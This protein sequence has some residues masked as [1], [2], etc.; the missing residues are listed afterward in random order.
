[1]KSFI[2][3]LILLI[4]MFQLAS[5][6]Y[7]D[8]TPK[9]SKLYDTG[10]IKSKCDLDAEELHNIFTDDVS[11]QIECLETNFNNFIKY[12]KRERSDAV[13]EAELQGFVRKFFKL[14]SDS[15]IKGLRF[16]FELNM[17]LLNDHRSSISTDNI[18]PLFLIMQKIN[19]HAVNIY[20]LMNK[21]N[22]SNYLTYRD[23]IINEFSNLM[24]VILQIVDNNNNNNEMSAKLNI[25]NFIAN[26]KEKFPSYNI[27]LKTAESLL[28]LKKLFLGG[29]KTYINS[30]EVI[31]LLSK[32]SKG[33]QIGL[34]LFFLNAKSFTEE[35]ELYLHYGK[36]IQDLRGLFFP[37]ND[38]TVLFQTEDLAE[39]LRKLFN[40]SIDLEKVHAVF[41]SFQKNLLGKESDSLK[42]KDL[43]VALHYLEIATTSIPYKN[44]LLKK[45]EDIDKKEYFYKKTIINEVKSDMIEFS[46]ELK[47]LITRNIEF[48]K[49]Q[50]ILEFAID[51]NQQYP[52][53]DKLT[54]DV[55]GSLFSVKTLLLGGAKESF[56]KQNIVDLLI[57]A[58]DLAENILNLFYINKRDL[59]TD[60]LKYQFFLEISNKLKNVFH[61]TDKILGEDELVI[62]RHELLHIADYMSK[63]SQEFNIHKFMKSIDAIKTKVIGGNETNYMLSDIH[64]IM[65]LIIKGFEN[66]LYFNE[67]YKANKR[68]FKRTSKINYIPRV[69]LPIYSKIQSDQL[70]KLHHS[71]VHQAK[72]YRYFRRDNGVAYY[73]FIIKRTRQGFVESSMINFI[74][75]ILQKAYGS[76]DGDN[77]IN[78]SR[79]SLKA[80][81][82]DFKPILLEFDMWTVS[83]DDFVRN[84]LL[85]SD[86][87]QNTSNST[88]FLEIDET[89]EFGILVLQAMKLSQEVFTT[90]KH[91][92][93]SGT[94]TAEGVDCSYED[95]DNPV[96]PVRCHRKFFFDIFFNKLNH[97]IDF[98]KF[99]RFYKNSTEEELDTYLMH[100]EGFSREYEDPDMPITQRDYG[101][102]IGA[103]LNIESTFIRFDKD[104]DN[105]LNREELD[106]AFLLYRS[107][108][109][110]LAELS[111]S[112]EKYAKSIFLYLVKNKKVP[113]K[114]QLLNFHYNPFINKD[115]V[116]KRLNLGAVL[117]FLVSK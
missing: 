80:L 83:F 63:E 32:A 92:Q 19:I 100:I 39:T 46:L 110:S 84:I 50:N 5:C 91:I 70:E 48:P 72:T 75:K 31:Q 99:F 9:V 73:N 106:Q 95:Q 34:D 20:K 86:L 58:P 104:E 101:M 103:L 85:L 94:A 89:T 29:N 116:A 67:T 3:K 105:V 36:S 107:A 90:L 64:K 7:F 65:D 62:K 12:V 76:V 17:I 55:I 82:L 117:Y 78:F 40:S 16:L 38:K 42:F 59:Y 114:V 108:I 44:E 96:F 6:G 30:N 74:F 60:S 35:K 22:H 21:I 53:A 71:F 2:Y 4:S 51:L 23:E 8:D 28:F 98:P 11:N 1:M 24:G 56:S 13:N 68:I 47:K 54:S 52:L 88:G 81:L 27:D 14:N 112:R 18:K 111:G 97:K 115:I 57:K 102:I 10:T 109:I 26:I 45:I 113:N 25:L 66:N 87:F 41:R 69:N 37:L 77:V 15:F 61:L 33:F 49:E 93:D 43:K 79:E